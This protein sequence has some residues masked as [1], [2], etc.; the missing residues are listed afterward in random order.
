MWKP[1]DDKKSWLHRTQ[2][3]TGLVL[4][5]I[6]EYVGFKYEIPFLKV[7]GLFFAADGLGDLITGYHHYVG[8]KAIE[9]AKYLKNKFRSKED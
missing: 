9:S 1:L 2:G 6:F 5:G 4:A 3:I 7:A 8:Q